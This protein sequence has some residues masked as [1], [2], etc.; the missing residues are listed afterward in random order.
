MTRVETDEHF[1]WLPVFL[2]SLETGFYFTMI[3]SRVG[4][5][6]KDRLA[7]RA[8]PLSPLANLRMPRNREP[9][10][11]A[12]CVALSGSPQKGSG[13]Q[14]SGV[15]QKA[16]C[17]LH[18]LNCSRPECHVAAQSKRRGKGT[19]RGKNVVSRF[20]KLLARPASLF[21]PRHCLPNLPR[22][23][24]GALVCRSVSSSWTETGSSPNKRSPHHH[25]RT[26]ADGK[27]GER[28]E[29]VCRQRELPLGHWARKSAEIARGRIQ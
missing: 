11:A 18:G 8:W 6:V 3:V 16:W 9:R 22:G 14:E 27:W 13:T 7:G 19:T 28:R 15:K 17:G 12:V 29:A 23:C 4:L 21:G 26:I 24:G 10:D 1:L 25:D 5:M 20:Q 2:G